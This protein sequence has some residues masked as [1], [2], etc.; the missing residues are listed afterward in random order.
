VLVATALLWASMILV[1]G[2]TLYIAAV[3]VAMYAF[4]SPVPSSDFESA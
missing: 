1:S 4:V 3:L 2:Q